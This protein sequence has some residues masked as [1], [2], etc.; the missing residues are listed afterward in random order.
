MG[1]SKSVTYPTHF[2]LNS[3]SSPRHLISAFEP[4]FIIEAND[5]FENALDWFD[6]D[7]RSNKPQVN[8]MNR[9]ICN[10]SVSHRLRMCNSRLPN[11]RF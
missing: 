6:P 5:L 2:S 7:Q 8:T 4:R 3:Q 1:S 11:Q 10:T 9:G